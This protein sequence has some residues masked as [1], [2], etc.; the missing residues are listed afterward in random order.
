MKSGFVSIV[1]K[2]N[3]GKST[4]IN[5]IV[6]SKVSIATP[7][8]QT[9][10]NA[11]QGIYNDK[12]AQ[13][14]FIDTPG[15]LIPHQKLDKYM[16]SQAYGSLSGIDAL[17]LLVDAG[18]PFNEEKDLPIA[19]SLS[20]VECPL[21]VVFNKIDLTNIILIE[22]LKAKYQELFPKAKIIE[23]SATKDVNIDALIR[24]IKYVLEEG[25]AFY[26]EDMKSDHP[27][28]FLIGEII[29]EKILLCL[30]AEV[31]HCVAVKIEQIQK[32]NDT[33]QID[34]T[35]ICEKPSQKGIIIGH[36]GKMLK[37]IGIAARKDIENMLRRKVN[38]K[39]FVRVE[40]KWRDSTN[41]LK[42]FGYHEEE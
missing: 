16:N 26:P 36:Q 3:A 19:K 37:R 42:E 25:Y 40:E 10:R 11:I 2:T 15:I 7:K 13:I 8:P 30:E 17:I 24:E 14:V 31:P 29:R 1:G 23:I 41:Y 22:K 12:D 4:L 35:I 18:N 5:R 27:I 39:T 38:L 32:V 28:S 21:F 33:L 34:A 6:K 20:N 9:T